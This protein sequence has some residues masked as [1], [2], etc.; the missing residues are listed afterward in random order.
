MDLK[1]LL[2]ISTTLL[3]DVFYSLQV[4]HCTVQRI[5]SIGMAVVL[6][7]VDNAY[8]QANL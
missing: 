5:D 6:V 1:N 3:L 8:S 2:L 4:T 7:F